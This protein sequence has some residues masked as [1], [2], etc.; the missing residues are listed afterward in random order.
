MKKILSKLLFAVVIVQVI[1]SGEA[2]ASLP[3][4]LNKVDRLRTVLI[5]L[6]IIEKEKA[7]NKFTNDMFIGG[8]NNIISDGG[9]NS[10][11]FVRQYEI[12]PSKDKY[13]K[14]APITYDDA[15]KCSL[16]ALGYKNFMNED[17]ISTAASLGLLKNIEYDG[18][19]TLTN[20]DGI[21]LLYNVMN[22]RPMIADYNGRFSV[23]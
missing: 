19:G 11:L 13:K 8:L 4:D 15:L 20:V 18:S 10:E 9:A 5:Q 12:I 1:L 16:F 23:S 7:Y 6:S 22:T 17:Y 21:Q 14:D 2:F 3:D